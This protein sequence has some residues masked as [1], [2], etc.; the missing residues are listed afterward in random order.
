MYY[1]YSTDKSISLY[2]DSLGLLGIDEE[3][4]TQFPIATFTRYAN[5]WYRRFV[6]YIWRSTGAWQFDDA[7]HTTLPEAMTTLVA[8]QGDY[9][10]PSTGIDILEAHIK[11]GNGDYKKLTRINPNNLETSRDEYLETAGTPA[12]FWLEG[13]SIILKPKPGTGH[14][15]A[16]EGL[17]LVLDR[18]IDAFT[19]T[20]TI[21]EPGLPSLFHRVIS[22]GAAYDFSRSLMM[23]EKTNV[24]KGDLDRMVAELQDYYARRSRNQNK[25]IRPKITNTA[26]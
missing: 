8:D 20:D 17:K 23:Q 5:A 10:L 4:T 7:N 18:D 1:N 12:E 2:H 15:T 3:N 13:N 19:S 16:S 26:I 9:E 6:F 21:Q 11:D 25:N 22:L 24:L 14:F